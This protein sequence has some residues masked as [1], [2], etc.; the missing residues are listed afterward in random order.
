MAKVLVIES[1]LSNEFS[2][3]EYAT[4]KFVEEYKKRN[5][6][7]EIIILDLNNEE[8]MQTILSKNNFASFW[9]EDSE[10][11]IDLIKSCDK[12]VI[13]TGMINFSISPLLKN[14][15]DHVL[16]ANK[17]FKY[18]YEEKGKSVGLLDSNKKVQLIMAQG[19]FKNWYEFSAF[20][21]YLIHLLKF[22]GI[23]REN[24]NVLLFDGTKTNEQKDLSITE[25]F[26]LK[27]DDFV[28]SVEV[29]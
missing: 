6:N 17:T 27:K 5:P 13:S 15:F 9:N 23:P 10:R 8:K 7:D 20:D 29:F 25:K 3:S 2:L 4:S 18:K 16:V 14:F 28:R 26:N 22:M 11:Y 19:S 21:D 24:I 1:Y 12:I